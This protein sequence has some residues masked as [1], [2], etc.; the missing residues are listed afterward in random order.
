MRRIGSSKVAQAADVS[1]VGAPGKI[2]GITVYGHPL[3]THRLVH[4][5]GHVIHYQDPY[6]ENT[7]KVWQPIFDRLQRRVPRS[8]ESAARRSGEREDA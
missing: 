4:E 3:A 7:D 5:C 8:L 6:Y 2:G 1:S